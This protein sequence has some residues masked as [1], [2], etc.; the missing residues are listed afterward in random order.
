MGDGK[1]WVKWWCE[2]PSDP[3]VRAIPSTVRWGFPALLALAKKSEREG[4]LEMTPGVPYSVHH[5]ADWCAMPENDL[6]T[7]CNELVTVHILETV[8]ECNAT[9]YRFKNW[10]KRQ[11]S[12]SY[13]RVKKHREKHVTECNDEKSVTE[14]GAVTTEVEVDVEVDVE[15]TK[16]TPLVTRPKNGRFIPPNIDEVTEYCNTRNNS[17]DPVKWY[18][19][20]VSNGWRVGKN[21]MKSWKAAIVTWEKNR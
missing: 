6:V 21:P 5:L 16:S 11:K 3:K 15:K 10:V 17:V 9:I 12:D 7:L 2:T 20:Y 8:T 18:A 13:S 1:K 19:Y 4:Y 14:S